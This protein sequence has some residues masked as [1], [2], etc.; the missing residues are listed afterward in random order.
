MKAK[1]TRRITVYDSYISEY[2]R[3]THGLIGFETTR[4]RLASH[5]YPT[6]GKWERIEHF[7]RGPLMLSWTAMQQLQR[8]LPPECV[9]PGQEK[10]RSYRPD[11]RL[12]EIVAAATP[13]QTGTVDWPAFYELVDAPAE[14]IRAKATMNALRKMVLRR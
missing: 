3:R 7:R 2:Q 8:W 10:L 9:A 6:L 14:E 12:T 4:M 11:V 5:R 1:V 13:H